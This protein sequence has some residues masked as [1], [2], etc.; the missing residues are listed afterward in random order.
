MDDYQVGNLQGCD[1]LNLITNFS[2]GLLLAATSGLLMTLYSAL[3]KMVKSEIDN[4]TVLI[5]RGIIQ[6]RKLSIYCVCNRI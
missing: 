2:V 3:Y 4:S 6:V 5:L 1:Y